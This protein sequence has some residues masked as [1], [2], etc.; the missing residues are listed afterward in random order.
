MTSA[1]HA[2]KPK[3]IDPTHQSKVWKI[4]HEQ[5]VNTIDAT[6]QHSQQMD[7]SKLSRNY[8]TNDQMLRYKCINNC[9]FMDTFFA[10]KKAGK[11]SQ[12]NSCCQLFVT[13]KGFVHAIPMKTR[14]DVMLAVKEFAK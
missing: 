11:S 9:F 12:G 5:A 2:G 3:G 13:D 4:S 7:D 10:I 1:T 8:G 14:L 6:T